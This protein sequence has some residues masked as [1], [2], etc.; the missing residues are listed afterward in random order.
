MFLSTAFTQESALAALVGGV[1]I[2]VC[3]SLY[4]YFNKDTMPSST[5]T[6]SV[7]AG[8]IVASALVSGAAGPAALAGSGFF[9]AGFLASSSIPWLVGCGALVGAGSLLGQGCTSGNGIQGLACMS[10]AS[11]AFVLIFM[12]AGAAASALVD[13]SAALTPAPTA[14]S[15]Q[16][17]VVAA[18]LVA[19]QYGL[20]AAGSLTASNVAAGCG[21]A[22]SLVQ[23]SMVKPSKVLGFL[24][25]A[26]SRGWD[27]SLAFVMGGAL[28]VAFPAFQMLG[29]VKN[30]DKALKDFAARP[31]DANTVLGGL[32]FGAGWGLGGLCPGP[33]IVS[34]G[35]GSVG[36]AAWTASMFGTRAVMN[37]L[38]ASDDS[39][40]K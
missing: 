5:L 13:Q 6:P 28:L 9:E 34:A 33:A 39:K 2:G 26:G 12:A 37:Q 31:I 38:G 32:L 7:H 14:F 3:A 1:G 10:K 17:A 24:N 16:L 36:A 21:F 20:G 23:A 4:T 19:A 11:L 40:K 35:T 18:A 8:M 22:V 27:P 29:L 15:S 25:F 30:G